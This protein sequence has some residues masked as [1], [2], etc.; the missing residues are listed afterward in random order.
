MLPRHGI[1]QVLCMYPLLEGCQVR[2][3]GSN[4]QPMG[5]TACLLAQPQVVDIMIK[6]TLVTC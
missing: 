4:L 2:Q 3:S 6:H 1:A 5:Q